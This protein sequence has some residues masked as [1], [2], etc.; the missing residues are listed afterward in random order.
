MLRI[1]YSVLAGSCLLAAAFWLFVTLGESYV[2]RLSIPLAVAGQPP[3]I[4]LGQPLPEAVEVTLTGTGWQLLFLHISNQLTFEIPVQRMRS[5]RVLLTNRYLAEA[6]KLPPGMRALRAYPE[7]LTVVI[8]PYAEKKVPLRIVFD[9]LSFREF[10]GL[11]GPIALE[12]DSVVLMGSSRVLREI[13][14][15]PTARRAYI[16]L[17]G[18]V[19]ED[20]RVA[21]SLPGVIRFD[22]ETARLYIPV[23]QIVDVTFKD[24]P[25]RV[26]GAPVAEQVLLSH[27][28]VDISVRGGLNR[29]TSLEADDFAGIIEYAAIADDSTGA[30]TPTIHLPTGVE[31][32]RISPSSIK[33][34]L[35][36]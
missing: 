4:A 23:E 12:P 20:V 16:E 27:S 34:T 18:P 19:S 36:K 5:D 33:Y 2:S 29:M 21:D 3:N 17:A 10:F 6:L 1:R 9:T 32:L 13:E 7:T 30:V 22:H 35:R 15:W 26:S 28:V 8:D 11:T 31:L 24:I 25:V 14:S